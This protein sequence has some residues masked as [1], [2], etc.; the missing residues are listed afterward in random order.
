VG[1]NIYNPNN[2][3]YHI[4]KWIPSLREYMET[5]AHV[6][7]EFFI[8]N[9]QLP[10]PP[11]Y[12]VV[13]AYGRVIP[14]G[15]DVPF[16]NA[17]SRFKAGDTAFRNARLKFFPSIVTGPW[18]VKFAANR[19][20]GSRP[21][22]IG[23]KLTATYNDGPNYIEVNINVGSSKIASSLNGIIVSS[24]KSLCVDEGFMIES[25]EQDELPERFI[26]LSRFIH[27]SLDNVKRTVTLPEDY[28]DE[29]EA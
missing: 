16:D 3:T 13:H 12:N 21:C 27:C 22:I 24:S 5:Y 17:Y 2:K 19:L 25:Q 9:W 4:S 6:Y 8:V 10:G 14:E 29:Q 1:L 28:K 18:A 20:G 11:H 7:S 26:G 15:V 23:K